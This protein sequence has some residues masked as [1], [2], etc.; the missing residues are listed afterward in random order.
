LNT[1]HIFRHSSTENKKAFTEE[2]NLNIKDT[3]KAGYGVIY[4]E[5]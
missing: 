5:D 3:M 4:K 1:D 2:S